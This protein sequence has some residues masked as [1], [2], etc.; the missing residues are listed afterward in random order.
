MS[1]ASASAAYAPNAATLRRLRESGFPRGRDRAAPVAVAGNERTPVAFASVDDA[2]QLILAFATHELRGEIA[3]QRTLAEVALADPDA[4]AAVLR[5]LGERVVVACERQERLLAALLSLAR[6]ECRRLRREPVDL[7]ATAAEV[8]RAQDHRGL[9]RTITLELA[10]TTGDPLLVER[11][12]ANLV[13]NAVRHNI[14]GGRVDVRTYTA[15]GR[16]VL[17]IAN[18]GPLIPAG[19]LTRLF[20]PFEQGSCRTGR[21]ADGL[22]LGLTIVQAIAH[23]HDA[24]V[25]TRAR[26]RGGLRIE[27][28]FPALD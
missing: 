14:A 17:T 28:A 25:T 7:A 20:Q 16:A 10:R 12:A 3:V 26:T 11:L 18:T 15:A 22:G 4:G 5:E 2:Q 6:S 24:T 8:L 23:A 27:V 19:D 9:R 1:I 21:P 13:A